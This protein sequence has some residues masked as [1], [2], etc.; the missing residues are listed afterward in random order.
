MNLHMQSKGLGR[1]VLNAYWLLVTDYCEMLEDRGQLRKELLKQKETGPDIYENSQYYQV[2]R[3]LLLGTGC[4][5][6]FKKW[7][8]EKVKDWL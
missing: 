2:A 7:S 1:K 5:S 8:R 6:I 3:M 4:Q